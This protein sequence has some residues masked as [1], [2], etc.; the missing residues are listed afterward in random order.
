MQKAGDL[1][2]QPNR[3]VS[4]VGRGLPEN[5]T[6]NI[7]GQFVPHADHRGT[8]R[9]Q[10]T[11]FHFPRFAAIGSHSELRN[12]CSTLFFP[13]LKSGGHLISPF[14][15]A[16]FFI[17]HHGM[18]RVLKRRLRPVAMSDRWLRAEPQFTLFLPA[19]TT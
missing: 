19:G 17:G 3:V 5:G 1:R 14:A 11:I 12:Q 9:F 8:E 15:R 13:S 7:G 4:F 2:S 10:N 6:L 16:M 18:D